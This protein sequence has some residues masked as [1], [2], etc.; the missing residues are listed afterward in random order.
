MIGVS[1]FECP[2]PE[3]FFWGLYDKN[4]VFIPLAPPRFCRLSKRALANATARELEN[5]KKWLGTSVRVYL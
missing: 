5:F 4:L 1:S 2:Y 3:Q